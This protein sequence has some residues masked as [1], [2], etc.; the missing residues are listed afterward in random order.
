LVGS[1]TW[2]NVLDP[3]SD[4]VLTN[5]IPGASYQIRFRTQCPSGYTNF[6]TIQVFVMPLA[7]P[8][9]QSPQS[10]SSVVLNAETVKLFWTNI[11][12]AIGYNVRYREFSSTGAY[13]S[14]T[15]ISD[16]QL[17]LDSLLP[18]TKYKW[19]VRSLCTDST[20]GSSWTGFSS[21]I[22]DFTTEQV[23]PACDLN[24]QEMLSMDDIENQST[25][26]EQD[27]INTKCNKGKKIKIVPNPNSGIFTLKYDF[28]TEHVK[29]NI[30]D[31]SGRVVVQDGQFK[32]NLIIDLSNWPD[33]VFIIEIID[34]QGAVTRKKL[35]KQN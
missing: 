35:V 5:L 17:T 28:V 9:S 30:F 32:T 13:I 3:T 23:T 11:G 16:N 8:V 10:L 34:D 18:N 20:G 21:P 31:L 29:Y 12:N 15:V 25:S 14:K 6:G 26:N 4:F 24:N 27:L 1:S 2:K 7:L 22:S 19:Q 33:G